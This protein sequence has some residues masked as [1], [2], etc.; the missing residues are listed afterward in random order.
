MNYDEFEPVGSPDGGTYST[1]RPT[2]KHNV[3]LAIAVSLLF[4][5]TPGLNQVSGGFVVIICAVVAAT[6][7]ALLFP[8]KDESPVQEGG[9]DA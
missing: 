8:V 1:A 9:V 4:S 2:R 5:Y 3:G 6:L 7:G